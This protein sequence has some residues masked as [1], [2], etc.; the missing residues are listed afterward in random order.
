VTIKSA[1]KALITFHLRNISS[2]NVAVSMTDPEYDI[3]LTVVDDENHAI[4]LT[5][6]GK[7]ILHLWNL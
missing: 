7:T 6:V 4:S 2:Q 5:K 1:E 3:L